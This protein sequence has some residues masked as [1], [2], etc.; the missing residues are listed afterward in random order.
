VNKFSSCVLLIVIAVSGCGGSSSGTDPGITNPANT[1]PKQ[2]SWN[3]PTLNTDGSLFTDLSIYRLYYGPDEGSLKMVMDITNLGASFTSYTFSTAERNTLA[4]LFEK[5]S[6][7]VFALTAI[8]SQNI[9]SSF[10]N[11]T[12]IF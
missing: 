3:P 12:K 1:I 11:V 10:S 7:H 2:I 9:E 6:T 5:N 8:N 4:S